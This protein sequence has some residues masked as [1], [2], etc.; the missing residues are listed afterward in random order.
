VPDD[1]KGETAP[2]NKNRPPR[3]LRDDNGCLAA[4]RTL[5]KTEKVNVALIDQD[6]YPER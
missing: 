1:R 5:A 2:G 6:A 4:T 3:D